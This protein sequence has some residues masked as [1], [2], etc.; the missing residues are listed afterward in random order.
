LQKANL[1]VER[2]VGDDIKARHWD[3]FFEFYYD[4]C[5]RKYGDAYLNRLDT[6]LIWT[7]FDACF[8]S[9]SSSTC[10]VKI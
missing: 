8:A 5:D 1:K 4:T 3:E 2:L 10:W 7:C 9:G 6:S